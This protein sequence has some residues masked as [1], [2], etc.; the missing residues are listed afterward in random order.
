MILN[1]FLLV[2]MTIALSC[3]KNELATARY[4][5]PLL[6]D[7]TIPGGL[8]TLETH[9]F[10]LRNIATNYTNQASL[11]GVDT[12]TIKRVEGNKGLIRSRFNDVNLDFIERISI[13][14]VSKKNPNIKRELY[15]LDFAP[16]NTRT[17]LRMLTSNSAIKE[18]LQEEFIDIEVRLLFRYVPP[19][20]IRTDIDFGYVVF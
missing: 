11:F 5:V 20:D 16:L 13:M 9:F 8:N 15:Y 12:S 14:L 19:Y 2:L 17:E 7:F 4:Q 3:D 1:I 10:I 6:V 18:L